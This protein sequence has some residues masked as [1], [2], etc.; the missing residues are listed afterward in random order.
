MHIPSKEQLKKIGKF[1]RMSWDE[2]TISFLLEDRVNLEAFLYSQSLF[3]FPR[4]ERKSLLKKLENN[5]QDPNEKLAFQY[6]DFA[7]GRADWCHDTTMKL[8]E[9]CSLESILSYFEFNLYRMIKKNICID[10]LSYPKEIIHSKYD[11]LLSVIPTVIYISLR[12]QLPISNK[13]LLKD[14][15]QSKMLLMIVSQYHSIK[16]QIAEVMKGSYIPKPITHLDEKYGSG[17]SEKYREKFNFF[18]QRVPEN[19]DSIEIYRDLNYGLENIEERGIE[20]TF[21]TLKE[22]GAIREATGS[23]FIHFDMSKNKEYEEIKKIKKIT[24]LIEDVYGSVDSEVR[25]KDLQFTIKDMIGVIRKIIRLSGLVSVH[26]QKNCKHICIYKQN[27]QALSKQLNLSNLEKEILPLLS[28]DLDLKQSDEVENRPF[29]NVGDMYY[30]FTPITIEL[31]YEKVVDKI[32][33]QKEFEVCLSHEGKGLLFEDKINSLFSNAN[34]EVGQ[35]K[36]NQKKK[37]PEIDAVV[38]FDDNNILVIEAKC[39]IKPEE[40]LEVFSFVENHLSKAANQLLERVQFLT[41]NPEVANQRLD[42]SINNK[43]II[44]IIVTNHSFFSGFKFVYEGG[45]VIYCIDELL[46]RK[47]ISKDCVPTWEY[48]G[49]ESNYIPQDRSLSTKSEKLEA[50]LDPVSNLLSKACRTIQPLGYGVVIEI[51]KQPHIDRLEQ[52]KRQ[53]DLEGV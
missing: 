6:L 37:V 41:S 16:R 51:S 8:V 14:S 30:M 19:L 38:N 44:P 53:V 26:R 42:F 7:F 32:L 11:F 15:D 9:G 49:V 48:T 35:I 43:K 52:L 3:K 45:L 5:T 17:A 34:F 36:R 31:C 39:T 10:G 23:G 47:I 2:F 33:S 20:Q 12:E 4:E 25:Y 46:L 22:A 29:F 13:K 40:R 18:L 21:S 28:A 1:K 27:F 24:E 50:I